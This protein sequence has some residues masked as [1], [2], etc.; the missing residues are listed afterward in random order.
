MTGFHLQYYYGGSFAYFT[1]GDR[2]IVPQIKEFLRVLG[3]FLDI[4]QP[5]VFMVDATHVES[6]PLESGLMIVKWMQRYR[7]KIP[8]ILLGSG[9]LIKNQKVAN[10]MK[11][12]FDKQK[13][14]SPNIISTNRG[15]VIT[16]LEK[17]LPKEIDV[18][19]DRPKDGFNG[20]MCTDNICI[21]E[22]K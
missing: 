1:M 11:W 9:I 15:K 21:L 13:P 20:S 4:K 14:V 12:V 10:L 6:F 3:T 8:G 17:H 19:Q 7:D 18:T 16:F 22:P 2:M 5:Y